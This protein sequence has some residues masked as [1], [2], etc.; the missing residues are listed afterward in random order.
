MLC[1]SVFL[2]I[3]GA[4]AYSFDARVNPERVPA[5]VT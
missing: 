4:G 5:V 3:V 1:G 2:L